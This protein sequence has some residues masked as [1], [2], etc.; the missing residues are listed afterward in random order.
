MIEIIKDNN[1]LIYMNYIVNIDDHSIIQI[2][3]AKYRFSTNYIKYLKTHN[4]ILLN[5]EIVNISHSINVGDCIS[6]I[7]SNDEENDNIVPTPMELNILYEDDFLLVVNKPFGMPI[8]PSMNHF[9]DSLSNGIKNYYIQNNFRMLLLEYLFF[10]E[11]NV[12]YRRKKYYF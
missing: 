5:N 11:K 10:L 1:N 7:L 6:I 2:L 4:K 3:K 8:H 12:D 9:T